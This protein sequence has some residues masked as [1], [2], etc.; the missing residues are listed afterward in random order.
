MNPLTVAEHMPL[1]TISFGEVRVQVLLPG[2]K[3]TLTYAMALDERMLDDLR[4]PPPDLEA[5]RRELPGV[6]DDVAF[7]WFKLRREEGHTR[8][9]VTKILSEKIAWALVRA[10]G[11]R[12]A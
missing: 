5:A 1:T 6:S 12:D 8:E 11:D 4:P 2:D 7:M 3:N 9:R 10:L